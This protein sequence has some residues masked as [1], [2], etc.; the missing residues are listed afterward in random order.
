M[1]GA[2]I[3]VTGF[4]IGA[5]PASAA[6][7]AYFSPVDG[8][9]AVKGS[10]SEFSGVTIEGTYDAETG[11][12]TAR[13]TFPKTTQIR[14]NALPGT[15]AEVVIQ[16]SQPEPGVGTVSETGDVVLDAVFQMVIE[17]VTLVNQ[18]TGARTPLPLGPTPDSCRFHPIEVGLTGTATGAEG[19]PLTVSVSD[20]SFVIPEPANPATDCG[21]LGSL[22]YPNVSGPAEGE[23]PNSADLSFVLSS[24]QAQVE[25]IYQAVLGRSA[26]PDGLAY[27]AG[28]IQAGTSPTRVAMTIA[29]SREGWALAVGDS[30]RIALDREADEDGIDWWTDA[31]VRAQDQPFLI[32]RLL[33]S[34]EAN[35]QAEDAFPEAASSNEAFVRNLYPTLFGRDADE[36][37]VAFWT[38]RLDAADNVAV[39][40]TS[41]AQR[42]YRN[43]ETVSYA[44][45]SASQAVCGTP[46]SGEQAST[47]AEAF[48][49]SNY[50]TRVLLA[51]AAITPCPVVEVVDE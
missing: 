7:E 51:I 27:W 24:A 5:S 8:N 44:V 13:A 26:E 21:P 31:L 12:L 47:L 45:D 10:P 50:H 1:V 20:D 40:R 38:A 39:A 14:E 43:N 46:A 35:R 9:I 49:T 17:S 22:I 48:T 42:L 30:Y 41:L 19:G 3:A 32:G 6:P 23:D 16:V 28:R 36:G 15:N 18:G 29:R 37:G 4:G 34:A 33:S 11:D 25:A 2:A